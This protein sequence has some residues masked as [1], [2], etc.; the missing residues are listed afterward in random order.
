MIV[1]LS[2][3]FGSG[4]ADGSRSG[5]SRSIDI[6]GR[7]NGWPLRLRHRGAEPRLAAMLGT[8]RPETVRQAGWRLATTR[9]VRA[10][11]RGTRRCPGPAAGRTGRRYVGEASAFRLLRPGRRKRRS[12]RSKWSGLHPQK[13]RAASGCPYVT[14]SAVS[15]V[16]APLA[17][18]AQK[19]PANPSSRRRALS[20]PSYR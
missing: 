16:G 5:T 7:G 2:V 13:T 19:R 4:F 14:R 17:N 8:R 11:Q 1:F 12:G 3:C 10:S 20:K 18:G 6:P 15:R 9:A